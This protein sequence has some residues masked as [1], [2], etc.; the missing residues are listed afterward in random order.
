MSEQMNKQKIVELLRISLV[1][2]RDDFFTSELQ[3]AITF[4]ENEMKNPKKECSKDCSRYVLFNGVKVEYSQCDTCLRLH[5]Y[6][7]NY[8]PKEC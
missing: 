4:L 3:K 6:S 2:S 7:D 5:S 8:I 1:H